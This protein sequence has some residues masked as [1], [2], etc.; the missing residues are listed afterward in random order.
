MSTAQPRWWMVS[1]WCP[2]NKTR[3]DRAVGPPWDQ[4]WMWWAS[5]QVCGRSQP[6]KAQP[7]SRWIRA[8]RM[9]A[10]TV[11]ERRPMSSTSEREPRT[12]GM[13]PASQ[14][15]RRTTAGSMTLASSP[16]PGRPARRSARV[17]VTA[18]VGR[19]SPGTGSGWATAARSRSARVSW[20]RR[21]PVRGSG[22]DSV[23]GRG[24]APASIRAR[25]WAPRAGSSQNAPSTEPSWRV[26]RSRKYPGSG[27]VPVLGLGAVG[28]QG[29]CAGSG[30]CGSAGSG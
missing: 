6:G 22:P 30:R 25:S 1:W 26:R 28:V 18:R 17:M 12:I 3:L 24:A 10:G 19:P 2:H 16:R 11:R 4:C 7:W 8:L 23:L 13:I 20:R 21:P 27:L 14:A 29:R 15:I 5:V 9:P